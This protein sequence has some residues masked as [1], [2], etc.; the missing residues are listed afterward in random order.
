MSE[1]EIGLSPDA[2]IHYRDVTPE[3]CEISQAVAKAIEEAINL[4][5]DRIELAKMPQDDEL[6]RWFMIPPGEIVPL[7]TLAPGQRFGFDSIKMDKLLGV[8]RL[9]TVRADG[10]ANIV[11]RWGPIVVSANVLVVAEPKKASST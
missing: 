3:E 8:C 9:E 4:E 6:P 2:K 7:A 11:T 1:A 5:P 10:M